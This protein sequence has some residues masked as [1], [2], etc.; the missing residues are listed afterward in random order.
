MKIKLIFSLIILSAVSAFSTEYFVDASRLDDSGT[1]TNWA[2]A[3]QSIQ[4]AVDLAVDGDTVWVTNGVYNVA[5]QIAI[6]NDITL[7]S[8]NGP[9]VT[10]VNA[11]NCRCFHLGTYACVVSGLTI[12][13]GYVRSSSSSWTSDLSGYGG[14]VFCENTTPVITNCIVSGNRAN[15]AAGVYYGTVRDCTVRNNETF[16]WYSD[17]FRGGGLYNS[18]S[19][20]CLIQSNQAA[21]HGGGMYGG[22]ASNCIFEG[23]ASDLYGGGG[24][25][26]GG[27]K[28][29]IFTNNAALVSYG[30]GMNGGTAIDCLFIDNEAYRGGGMSGGVASRCT[31][32]GN[33]ASSYGGGFYSLTA[34]NCLVVYNSSAVGGAGRYLTANNCTIVSNSA[35]D[36]S[37]GV[38]QSTVC[39]SIVYYNS[40]GEGEGDSETTCFSNSCSTSADAAGG[41]IQTPPLFEDLEAQNFRLSKESLC[42]NA[43][44]NLYAPAG[45]DLDGNPR[46]VG[47]FVDM[48]SYE[49]YSELPVCTIA[50]TAGNYGAISPSDVTVFQ[51]YDRTFLITPD[52][53]YEID[54]LLVDEFQVT[55]SDSYTFTNVQSSHTISASFVPGY[56]TLLVSEGVGSGAYAAGV[57]ISVIAD[58]PPEG[59]AFRGWIISPS[60][61]SENMGSHAASNTTFMMPAEPVSLTA[62]YINLQAVSVTNMVVQQ[63]EGSKFVD[64]DYDVFNTG[65]SDVFVSL[66]VFRGTN[67]ISVS[68][69]SGDVGNVQVGEGKSICWNAESDWDGNVGDLTFNLL[70]CRIPAGGDPT[71]DEWDLV[72]Q[73]WVKNIYS[74]GSITMSD[75]VTTNMWLYDANSYG[76]TSYSSANSCCNG[77]GYAGYSDWTLSSTATLSAQSLQKGYFGNYPGVPFGYTYYWSTDS[78]VVVDMWDGTTYVNQGY[79][80]YVWPVRKAIWFDGVQ[81]TVEV[82]SSVDTQDYTLMVS[83]DYGTSVPGVGTNLFAWRSCVTCAV[84]RVVNLGEQYWQCSGWSGSGSVPELGLS[85][86]VT[87]IVLSNLNSSIVWNWAHQTFGL[88]VFNGGG[89]GAYTNGSTV[90]VSA[91]SPLVGTVFTGWSA[92]PAE[93]QGRLSDDA[94]SFTTFTMPPESVELFANYTNVYTITSDA[95]ANGSILPENPTLF[96][97]ADQAFSIQALTGY[98]IDSVTVDGEVVPVTSGYTF[99][100]VQATH[101]ITATFVI[102]PHV[103]TVV[104]GAGAGTYT[105]G[106]LVPIIAGDPEPG[107]AFVGWTVD[108]AGFSDRI[109]DASLASTTFDMPQED[110]T[111]SA[112]YTPV[113]TIETTAGSFGSIT[114]ENPVVWAGESC[115]LSILPKDLY[116]VDTLVVDG[117]GVPVATS[118]TFDDVSTNHMLSA[119]FAEDEYAL[120]VS[121]GVGSGTYLWNAMVPV[122]ADDPS[123]GYAFSEWL[124]EPS[125]YASQFVDIS[126]PDT[127]FEMPPAAVT[128]TAVYVPIVYPLTVVNGTGS[129]LYE[130]D[131]IDEIEA[132][133][134]EGYSFLEW[135]VEPAQYEDMLDMFNPSTDFQMPP[136]AVTITAVFQLGDADYFVD[137]DMSDDSGDGRSWATAKRT[138][139]AAVD[140][141]EDGEEILVAAG[142]YGEGDV[143]DPTT[144]DLNRVVITNA[145]K[146]VSVEGPRR[147]TI[148]GDTGIRGAFLQNGAILAG[149]TVT[150]GSSVTCGG[151]VYMDNGSLIDCILVGNNSDRSGGG[152]FSR[153]ASLIDNCL[154]VGNECYALVVGYGYGGGVCG[155]SDTVILN[156]TLCDNVSVALIQWKSLTRWVSGNG[157]GASGCDLKN[158][159]VWNNSGSSELYDCD[160]SYSC[161]TRNVEQGVNGCTTYDPLFVGAASGD[162]RLQSNSPC[163][164]WGDNS[165]V[166]TTNDLDGNPRIV[167]SV[168]DIGAYEYQT[169]ISLSPNDLDGDSIPDE[170][171]RTYGGNQFPNALSA[172][173]ADTVMDSYVVGLD[174]TNPESKFETAILPGPSVSWSGVTGRVY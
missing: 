108:P 168:V 29:C 119:T 62:Q 31:V 103:L 135:Q 66:E 112:N 27:A 64:I 148:I 19:E 55:V 81:A 139:Q 24:M 125:V 30:G 49:V 140:L 12:Q 116:H 95:G 76:V 160:V 56:Y 58:A 104:T 117:V 4:S 69:L 71:A 73:R 11:G 59:F 99:T 50:A 35:S 34:N 33:V 171:E 151:G 23:N 52:Y 51:G 167:D 9:E 123:A 88:S 93:Y 91:D 155:D 142:E 61:Y 70:A 129:G 174:P 98:R 18:Y 38:F 124:V 75:R 22:S 1:A 8:M 122:S 126:S 157:G 120:S 147:T 113:Y 13:G 6:Q 121:N 127:T 2:T 26:S 156:S 115:S 17:G 89:D 163:I 37:G 144:S 60:A 28:N 138:I 67:P 118:Y 7:Q 45:L 132:S 47:G 25:C 109:G 110:V 90:S 145:V 166:T 79:S 133:V 87:G 57:E 83:S 161:A 41:N 53:G 130:E 92:D 141:A 3:K 77:L 159:I 137:G 128:L 114:P 107:Y 111:L 152:A 164:N 46:I 5:S 153:G 40:S 21:Y 100:N 136:E 80:A 20:N 85:N 106:T 42:I 96:E 74:D 170:W 94:S 162:Y 44:N 68:A 102:D 172:N 10:V 131:E 36:S 169:P 63:R 54:S 134:P 43:G 165:E 72:N 32:V 15:S 101:T 86:S 173:S 105:N 65:D 143:E 48:G 154:F 16:G 97:G 82:F 14:G 78:G 149:F 146:V 39:N 150:N 158:C 84:E